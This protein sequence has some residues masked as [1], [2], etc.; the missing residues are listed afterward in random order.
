MTAT[1]AF[2]ACYRTEKLKVV[3]YLINQGANEHEAHDAAQAA[4][5]QA[6]RQWDTIRNP[7]NWLFTVARREFLAAQVPET[8]TD[9]FLAA[10]APATPSPIDLSDQAR[11]VLA[12]LETL[13]V[14][15]RQ[16]MALSVDEFTPAEI[17]EQLRAD[18]DTVR[19]NLRKARQNLKSRL[20][21][22][23]RDPR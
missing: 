6:F 18:R 12:T 20:G 17:A 21:I 15:Q 13:P 2:A 16:V 4:F 7:R 9:T 19:Q 11:E 14:K 22:G 5:M 8:P 3:R 1:E 23:G 10:Q